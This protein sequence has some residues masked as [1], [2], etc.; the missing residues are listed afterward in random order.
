[1]S[2]S[3]GAMGQRERQALTTAPGTP[4]KGPHPTAL[5]ERTPCRATRGSPALQGASGRAGKAAADRTPLGASVSFH[6]ARRGREAPGARSRVTARPSHTR[7][8]PQVRG[9]GRGVLKLT[10]GSSR[11][12]LVGT[13]WV[14]GEEGPA[15]QE[16]GGGH[17]AS[18]LD[19]GPVPTAR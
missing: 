9:G 12:S 16:V 14:R 3:P 13:V 2:P 1:M 8:Q 15:K 6:G 5:G 10:W 7:R 17:G 11:A 18:D 19:R 4:R